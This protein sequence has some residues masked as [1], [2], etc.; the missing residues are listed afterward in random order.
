[1]SRQFCIE[2]F[3]FVLISASFS[4][5]LSLSLSLSHIVFLA[6]QIYELT[7]ASNLHTE[8]SSPNNLP[9]HGSSH[10]S[11]AYISVQRF[12]MR[13][14]RISIRITALLPPHSLPKFEPSRN[15]QN[16]FLS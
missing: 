4:L 7:G 6:D 1:M 3:N 15:R 16:R 10:A 11:R 14:G 12:R 13:K 9:T 8:L 2:I 5:F